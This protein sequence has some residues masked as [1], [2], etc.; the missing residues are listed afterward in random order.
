MRE[1]KLLS[2]EGGFEQLTKP[3]FEGG[4][5]ELILRPEKFGMIDWR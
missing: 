4:V 2:K 1:Q 5:K 3:F